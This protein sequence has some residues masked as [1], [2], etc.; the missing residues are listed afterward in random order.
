MINLLLSLAVAFLTALGIRLAHFPWL[1]A[2]IPSLI[3]LVACYILLARRTSKRFQAIVSEVQAELQ[4]MQP[5]NPR[6][7]KARVDKA[8]QKME[9]ARPLGRWQFMI[10][11]EI[12]GFLGMIRYSLRE[13]TL[14]KNHLQK[15]GVRN[16]YASAIQGAIAFKAKDLQTM[17]KYFELAVK[18]GKKEGLMWAAYAWCLLQLKEKQKALAVLSRATT[19]NPSDEKLKAALHAVQNDKR[20]KMKTWE[21]AWW[22]LGLETPPTPQMSP[23]AATKRSAM[24]AMRR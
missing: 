20:L 11:K 13:E 5:T 2:L 24:R 17:Q 23:F 12:E 1:A 6:E 8:L 18:Y 4:T 9:T 21:P 3:L 7:Q 16:F 15:A 22:Q 14:A 10:D 19:A